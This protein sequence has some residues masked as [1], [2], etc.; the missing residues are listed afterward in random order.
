[1]S[2]CSLKGFAVIVLSFGPVALVSLGV[3]G[4]ILGAAM[5][6]CAGLILRSM[7]AEVKREERRN[8]GHTSRL[9]RGRVKRTHSH[10]NR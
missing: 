1:M 7:I 2:T 9:S 8:V 10:Y 3:L 5:V 6:G 4:F